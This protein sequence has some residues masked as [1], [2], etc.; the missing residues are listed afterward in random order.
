MSTRKKPVEWA[1]DETR[2]GSELPLPKK[3]VRPTA[4]VCPKRV[5]FRSPQTGET[6]W[7]LMPTVSIEG[8]WQSLRAIE[9]RAKKQIVLLYRAGFHT[10]K[11]VQD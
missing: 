7:L 2:L 6:Y 11:A 8:F 9:S 5:R 3:G 4:P 10:S 1:E